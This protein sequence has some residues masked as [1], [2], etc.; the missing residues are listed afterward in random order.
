MSTRTAI[1]TGAGRNIGFAIARHLALKRLRVVV[2]ALHADEAEHAAAALRS[3]GGEAVGVAADVS[4][5]DEVAALFDVVAD[6]WGVADVLVNNAAAPMVARQPLL[7]VDPGDWDRSFAV[8]ARSVFLCVREFAHAATQGGKVAASDSA[9]VNISSVGATRAHRN[10]VAYDATKGAVEAATRSMA[11]DL[12]P[13]GIR[14]N[15]VSPG[16][17]INDRLAGADPAD[18]AARAATIPLG[19]IGTGDDVATA[20]AFLAGSESAYVTGQVLQVDG[21]LSA[22]ARPP[23]ADV[24]ADQGPHT[25]PFR[26]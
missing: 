3:T 8:N 21:G 14:V 20:V 2:N 4:D 23:G 9:V 18:L 11:L 17:V 1:V 25:T 26:K 16:A 6:R 15:A 22:Q 5:P 10:A 12:A 7:Q 13:L 24:F 19:R